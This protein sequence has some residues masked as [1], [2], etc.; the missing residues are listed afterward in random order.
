MSDPPIE[1]T[2]ERV[3]QE[4]SKGSRI[5]ETVVDIGNGL[6][7]KYGRRRSHLREAEATKLIA[8]R[9]TIPV[10]T[11]IKVLYDDAELTTYIISTKLPGQ[12]LSLLL[13]TLNPDWK[14]T[15]EEDIK[16]IMRELSSLD[17]YGPLGMVGSPSQFLDF[18]D[19]SAHGTWEATNLSEFVDWPMQKAN[20]RWGSDIFGHIDLRYFDFTKPHVFSH[21][22]LVFDSGT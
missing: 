21:G 6:V 8:T 4:I 20:K 16:K 7:V 15:I 18:H 11:I 17:T 1:W 19:F 12:S 5:T 13:P 10:S 3:K 14:I 2:L 22:D 9:T